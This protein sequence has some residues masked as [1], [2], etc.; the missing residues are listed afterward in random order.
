LLQAHGGRDPIADY[1]R[2]ELSLRQLRVMV[3]HLPPDSAAH[4][5]AAGHDWQVREYLL[6]QAVDQ[7]AALFELTRAAHFDPQKFTAP[8]LVERPGDKAAAAAA[9]AKHQ[10][11]TDLLMA[12]VANAKP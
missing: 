5:A 10:K 7:L 4:R 8:T 2:G 12:M 6:A 3:E 11:T 9:A 1:W